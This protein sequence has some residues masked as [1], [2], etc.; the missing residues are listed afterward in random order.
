MKLKKQDKEIALIKE[1]LVN[2]NSEESFGDGKSICN[3]PKVPIKHQFAD[4]IYIRQM[5]LKQGH[6]IIGAVHNHLHTW[7]LMKGHV[8]INNNGEIIEHIA[9]CY[10]VSNP[11]SQRL[12]YAI[13]DSIFVNVH[14]N[15]TNTKN[16]K[17]L[18][19]EIVSMTLEEYNKKNSI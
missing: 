6:V 19:K 4:Q 2:S 1:L 3:T 10:T 16:I 9:P 13:E 12:I 14:K 7:F 15:P 11:G 8:I 17:E 5:D 18:E